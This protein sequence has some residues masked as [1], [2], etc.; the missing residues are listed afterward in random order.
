MARVAPYVGAWIETQNQ[1]STS[2]KR[3]VAPYVGAWIETQLVILVYRVNQVAPY[4]GAWIETFRYCFPKV[5]YKSHPTWVRGL[6]LSLDDCYFGTHVSH[7]TWVRG[8]KQ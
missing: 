3:P 7:P 4:V 6:K 8:L 5:W 2:G 1:R